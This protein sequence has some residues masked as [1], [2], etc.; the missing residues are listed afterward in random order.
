MKT[1]TSNHPI[2]I[3]N[4]NTDELFISETVAIG[5]ITQGKSLV[6][7]KSFGI[8]DLWNLRRSRKVR[9]SFTRDL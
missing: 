3:R 9:K 2:E 8:V 5:N 1:T 6:R 4:I 7:K